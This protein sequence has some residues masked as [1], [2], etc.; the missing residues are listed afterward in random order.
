MMLGISV[1][2][3]DYNPHYLEQ[4]AH[5][6][7]KYVFTSL[8]IP[9][10]DYSDLDQKLPA[11]F[12]KCKTLGLQVIPDVSPATFAKLGIEKGD[13]QELSRRGF[14]SLRL[15]YGF[16]D[17]KLIKK[18]QENFFILLNASVVTPAY[19]RQARKA[20]IDLKRVALTYNF[21]P[22]TDTGLGWESFK[23][24]NWLLKDEGLI[25]Q[26]FVAGDV[27]KR[28]PLY[29]GLPTVE[30]QRT[31]NPYVA[32][33][34]LIHEANVDDVFIG[35]SQ[36]SI[37][38]LRN[39]VAYQK[40]QVLHLPC[41]LLRDYKDLYG[42]VISLRADQPENLVRLLLPRKAGVAIKNN[43][44]RRRGSIIM[45]NKLAG[46]YSG[47][48]YLAKKN[49]PFE[50]RSNVIGFIDPSYLPLLDEIEPSNKIVFD[51]LTD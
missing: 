38:S 25:T 18:L 48:V 33:V 3:K 31:M 47:E 44:M 1:Y 51:Q 34:Q 4:A 30:K 27:L 35:D 39:I 28:F 13:Y 6:G 16:D 19:L 32:A 14:K 36:A 7:A 43:N 22:H 42:Q 21:Y 40:K 15:D 5:A 26:A 11:F 50:A 8:Q 12:S 10:E 45:Q 46:R 37:S 24:R 2:F 23:R 49:L 9:E 20:G 29:E 41:H 17:F